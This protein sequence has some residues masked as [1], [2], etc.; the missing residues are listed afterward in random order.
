MDRCTYIKIAGKEYP[1]SF[2]LG[3]SKKMIA[4]YGSIEK[5]QNELKKSGDDIKKLDLLTE[6]LALLIAQGCA[7]KNYFEK[8]MP[9]PENA[10]IING[11]W[12]PI[13]AEVLDIAIMLYDADEIREKIEECVTKGAKKR[14]EAKAQGKNVKATQA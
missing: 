12:E 3:A 8:D 7:Y 10:P 11:K 6:M 2:S 5:M 1:M 4:K 13:T 14:V 9:A